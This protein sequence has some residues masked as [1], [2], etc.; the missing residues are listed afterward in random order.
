MTLGKKWIRAI[1]LLR[2]HYQNWLPTIFFYLTG[3]HT[4]TLILR[5]GIQLRYDAPQGIDFYNLAI[6]L[7]DGWNVEQISSKLLLLTNP[8]SHIL[9]WSLSWGFVTLVEIFHDFEYGSEFSG[10]TIVDIGCGCGDSLLHFVERGASFVIGLEPTRES[11]EL[12]IENVKLNQLEDKVSVVNGAL[13]SS[14]AEVTLFTSN[15]SPMSNATDRTPSHGN[16]SRYNE[17][18]KVN[19]ITWADLVQV[20]GTKIVDLLKI[21]CE[22]CEY[23]FLES[24]SVEQATYIREMV[25]EYHSGVDNLARKMRDL[26]YDVS[27]EV[28][29]SANGI[30]RGVRR[31]TLCLLNPRDPGIDFRTARS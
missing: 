23:G 17:R 6:L 15:I 29:G 21:D 1:L 30:L 20:H 31:E 4:R 25:I 10:K 22:G 2:R 11:Y 12:A 9:K 27:I 24:I 28:K 18:S 3:K 5:N 26:G 16:Y 8:T 14:H 13:V 7:N 19:P